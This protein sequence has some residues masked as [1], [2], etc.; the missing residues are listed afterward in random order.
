[1][2]QY[3]S[4]DGKYQQYQLR[5]N[6]D[7]QIHQYLKIGMDLNLRLQDEKMPSEP[8][9][10]IT[11][12]IWFNYPIEHAFYPNGLPYFTREGGGN[13]VVTNS[14]DI[15]WNETINKIIQTK[16]SFEYSLD[17]ITEGLEIIGY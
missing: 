16:L 2:S 12:R 3:S 15:G 1:E 8:I 10:N 11:H 17:W 5:S 13:P 9:S 7:A 4:K 14:F 6:I